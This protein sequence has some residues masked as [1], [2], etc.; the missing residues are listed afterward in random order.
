MHPGQGWNQG[1]CAIV[2]KD[3]REIFPNAS[4]FA[5]VQVT[6]RRRLTVYIRRP[7]SLQGRKDEGRRRE[8]DPIYLLPPPYLL[9]LLSRLPQFPIHAAPK[10][11]FLPKVNIYSICSIPVQK[12]L[13]PNWEKAMKARSYVLWRPVLLHINSI[14]NKWRLR[15]SVL[16]DS[17]NS[18]VHGWQRKLEERERWVNGISLTVRF[19]SFFFKNKELK[20]EAS[21]KA[22]E[23]TPIIRQILVKIFLVC[24]GVSFLK[25][26]FSQGL[27]CWFE[28]KGAA[29]LLTWII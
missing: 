23:L 15:S 19:F 29:L 27:F 14:R 1:E 11:I 2:W 28:L 26:R 17:I 18:R 20:V 25:S 10:S 22:E 16:Q 8:K 4:C 5:S 13:N 12:L 24:F 9:F 21:H 3:E 6:Y 7:S